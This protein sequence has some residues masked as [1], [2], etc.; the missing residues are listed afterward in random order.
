MANGCPMVFAIGERERAEGLS[1]EAA[2]RWERTWDRAPAVHALLFQPTMPEDLRR[3]LPEY[4]RCINLMSHHPDPDRWDFVQ[5]KKNAVA[6]LGL[7]ER[8][9]VQ[10][11]DVRLILLGERVA[12]AFDATHKKEGVPLLLTPLIKGV[13]IPYPIPEYYGQWQASFARFLAQE[14]GRGS[15]FNG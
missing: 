4:A 3:F 6:V 14:G 2:A 7:L 12:S 9:A 13:W 11:H 15:H 8:Y 5:A 1:A 10:K